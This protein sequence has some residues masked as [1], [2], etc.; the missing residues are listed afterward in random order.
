MIASSGLAPASLY[1]CNGLCSG[2]VLTHQLLLAQGFT[3]SDGDG[4]LGNVL[5]CGFFN[6]S[7]VDSCPNSCSGH[8]ACDST[9]YTCSCFNGYSGPDCS[10]SASLL[11]LRVPFAV[12]SH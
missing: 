3:R 12:D 10:R 7:V 2:H 11:V 5:D 9:D 4:N 1:A 6:G 8:G